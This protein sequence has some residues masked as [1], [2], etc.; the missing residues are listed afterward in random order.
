MAFKECTYLC[1]E[2]SRGS[3]PSEQPSNVLGIV[4]TVCWSSA[5]VARL[6]REYRLHVGINHLELHL[7]IKKDGPVGP[8]LNVINQCGVLRF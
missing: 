4:A 5:R 6:H 8:S 3:L 7:R 2:T 1:V